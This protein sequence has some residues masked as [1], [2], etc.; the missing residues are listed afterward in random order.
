[1]SASPNTSAPDRA[2]AQRVFGGSLQRGQ[3]RPL[4]GEPGAAV[5][6][7]AVLGVEGVYAKDVQAVRAHPDVNV[8]ASV[9]SGRVRLSLRA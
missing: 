8:A 6:A 4:K 9:E 1:M 3:P 2:P 7:A 5:G